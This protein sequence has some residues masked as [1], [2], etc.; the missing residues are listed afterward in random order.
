MN[1]PDIPKIYTALAEW[2]SCCV[3]VLALEKRYKKCYTICVLLPFLPVFCVLQYYI[4]VWPVVVWIPSMVAAMILIYLCIFSCC[5][6]NWKMAM[7]C[8]ATAFMIAEFSASFE[9][10][11]YSYVMGRG[12]DER[13][14]ELIFLVLFYSILFALAYFL[15]YRYFSGEIRGDISLKEALSSVIMAIAVFL[16]SNISYVYPDT[17][18]SSS[19][20]GGLFYIRTLVDFSGLLILF[21]QR[22][23]WRELSMQKEMEAVNAILRRQYEQYNLS[24]ENIEIINRKYH[25]LKHQIAVVRAE[26]NSDKRE[27]YLQEMENDIKMYE[28]QNKTGNKVLDTILTGKH[29]YC[30]Q[31]EINFT[32]VADGM[33]LDFMNLMDICTIFG[34]ALDNAIEC[35]EKIGDKSKR[36]IRT[37]VYSQSKFLIIRF[38]NY[39]ELELTTKDSLPITTK[40]DRQY[41]GYGLKSIRSTVEK[42]GGSMTVNVKDNWFILRLLIPE[43][44][45]L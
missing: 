42:Y 19:L 20:P 30:V 25:D 23:R 11:I 16:I 15:E 7:V 12:H 18:F 39:T 38:E 9:W 40:K 21:L 4:G 3:F 24:K 26:R 22:D 45:S 36:L 41:H 44:K 8:F 13:V 17:P 27:Q 33:L 6:V 2:F 35:V 14:I 31:H 34:N 37:A 28:A 10:Q 43:E 5:K 1:V 32:C 29:L